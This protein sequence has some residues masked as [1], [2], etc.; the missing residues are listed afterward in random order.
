M[1]KQAIKRPK[2]TTNPLNFSSS[3]LRKS[4]SKRMIIAVP[5]NLERKCEIPLAAF[6]PR[7]LARKVSLILLA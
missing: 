1:E 3:I 6:W 4:A 5:M 7:P 2:K